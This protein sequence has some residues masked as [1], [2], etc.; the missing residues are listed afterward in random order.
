VEHRPD[1][2]GR[3][4]AHRLTLPHGAVEVQGHRDGP[5]L[6]ISFAERR[7]TVIAVRHGDALNIY[8]D[9]RC[10]RLALVDPMRAAAVASSSPGTL[11]APIPGVIAA[12]FVKAG[13]SVLRGAPLLVLEA[14]KMEH[15]IR[16]PRDGVVDAVRVAVGAQV[17]EGAELVSLRVAPEA[18]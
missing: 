17:Q 12:V 18:G 1:P 4:D 15:Q 13:E 16:A 8:I 2:L 5:A 9:G 3:A 11:T 6:T 7:L 10:Y 14:M